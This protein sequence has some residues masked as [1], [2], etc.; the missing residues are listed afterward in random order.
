[1]NLGWNRAKAAL[2]LLGVLTAFWS[3]IYW[4]ETAVRPDGLKSRASVE[5]W[6]VDAQ[7]NVMPSA[8]P[9]TAPYFNDPMYRSTVE[10]GG[11]R[12]AFHIPFNVSKPQSD[13]AFFIGAT[14]G[15]QEIRLNGQ[16]IQPN[17]PLDTLRGAAD[18]TALYY[19]LPPALVRPGANEIQVFVE[20]QST[21]LALAPFH[22]GPAA[23]AARATSMVDL[24]T[25]NIPIIAISFL[26]FATLLCYVTNWPPEDRGRIRSLMILMALWAARTYLITFQTPFEVPFLITSFLYYLLEA[27]V[28]I[29]FARHL[30]A[31][32]L[33]GARL[34]NWMGWLWIALLTY[35]ILITAA[36]F[37]IGP[38]IRDWFKAVAY[39]NSFILLVVAISGLGALAW[40][41]ASRRDGRWLERLALMFCLLALFVDAGDS[42]FDLNLPFADLPLTFYSA[43]PAGLLLGLGVV[44]SIAREA[45]EAR[46]T[47]L[48]SNEILSAK[49]VEQNAELARSYDAQKQML[50]RQVILEERQRIVRDMHDGIGGQLLGLMMQ[51][52]GGGVEP[53]QVEEGLQSSIADLRLIVDSMDTADEGLAETLRSFEHRVRAQVEASGMRLVVH[54]GLDEEEPGPGPRPTLQILR[55][56]QEAVTNAMRHSGGHEIW[57]DSRKDKDGVIHIRISDDGKGLPDAIKGG[58]GLTSMRSRAEAIGGRLTFDSSARGT[59]AALAFVV[60][61]N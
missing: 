42:A 21:I 20:T 24:I 55:I 7:G 15:L 56:L 19:V 4:G 14:P 1:M 48:Q 39:F 25:N 52:R 17:I 44:A 22:I 50:Q 9:L 59:V 46:R 57:L 23:E 61:Q 8:K 36:G 54:H 45:S 6:P 11:S 37:A 53:K 16:V 2:A 27:S 38:A 35:L 33:Q 10:E 40:G 34:L 47:V 12:V 5:Y 29:A 41:L 30:L 60:P 51:V 31:G 32:E 43:A 26:I 3:A 13:L 58:R 49:L 28:I 18:G